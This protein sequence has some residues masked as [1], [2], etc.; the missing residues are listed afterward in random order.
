ML[1]TLVV[2]VS[3]AASLYL[4]CRELRF[5]FLVLYYTIVTTFGLISHTYAILSTMN[6]NPGVIL[7]IMLFLFILCTGYIAL[8]VFMKKKGVKRVSINVIVRVL[9]L[10]CLI[11]VV[12][13][14]VLEFLLPLV[15]LS[16]VKEN[17]DV[18]IDNLRKTNLSSTN[19]VEDV[20]KYVEY[21]LNSSW[22][23]PE[24]I[25]EL[26]NLLSDT[27]YWILRTLGFEKAYVIL[28]Q[29]WGSCGEYATVTEFLLRELGFETRIAKFE[30]IDHNWAEIK[31]NGSWYIVDPW[32][33]GLHYKNHLLVPA[34]E[35]AS[36]GPF[37]GNHTVIVVYSDG[38][39]ADA[40]KEHGYR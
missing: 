3:M 20:I 15:V 21:H 35:L 10:V 4:V 9:V 29:K 31:L 39:E 22:G 18:F 40:S 23:K 19:L 36:L 16:P 17:V 28:F 37:S 38:T 5:P 11:F 8:M 26:D 33:I 34:K 25:L 14:M 7:C 13:A 12:S 30:N 27:D 24:S 32:Y 6:Q 2:V 1:F